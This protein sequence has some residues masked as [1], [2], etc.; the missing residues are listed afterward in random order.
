MFVLLLTSLACAVAASAAAGLESLSAG[1]SGAQCCTLFAAGGL[2]A[3]WG[4]GD[5][6]AAGDHQDC[7]CCFQ[8]LKASITRQRASL[9]P[10]AVMSSSLH[11]T[12]CPEASSAHVMSCCAF[13]DQPHCA[14]H[15]HA[16][17]W[18]QRM[19]PKQPWQ[20]WVLRFCCQLGTPLV[21]MSLHQTAAV[22][23]A[24]VLLLQLVKTGQQV[25]G[26]P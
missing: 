4:Q 2:A 14:C 12:R 10:H 24:T 5:A 18:L 13:T 11:C 7:C 22:S 19:P 21:C 25:S 9:S 6:G 8:E 1:C 15:R 23:P 16:P 20:S 3:V 26:R 17:H